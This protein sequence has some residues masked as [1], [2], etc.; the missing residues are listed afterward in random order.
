MN[1]SITELKDCLRKWRR[2]IF[3]P[4]I[5]IVP[6]RNM[7]IF[8]QSLPLPHH[9]WIELRPQKDK[10]KRM[11]VNLPKI[12]DMADPFMDQLSI[13]R[14]LYS[15]SNKDFRYVDYSGIYP[16]INYLQDSPP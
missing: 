8:L 4:L 9:K 11:Q 15:L 13:M 16:R 3:N 12:S 10:G 6:I 14:V 7:Q 5:M 2:K 1:S